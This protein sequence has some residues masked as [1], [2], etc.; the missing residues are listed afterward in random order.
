LLTDEERAVLEEA[1]QTG[2][3]S[4][5]EAAYQAG[6]VADYALFPAGK[7]LR[8]KARARENTKPMS[9][10]VALF[11]ELERLAGVEPVEGRAWHG[12]RRRLSDLAEPLTSDE[13]AKNAVT[14]HAP[15]SKMRGSVYQESESE[16]VMQAAADV[17]AKA[18][19]RGD[20]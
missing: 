19:P 18:R 7:L 5:L 8:G 20:K 1:M 16:A 14:G 12:M 2:Y 17:R 13:R 6:D 4:A 10:L 15:G 11:H 3:L 9:N